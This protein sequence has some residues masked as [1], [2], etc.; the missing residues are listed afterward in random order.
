[1]FRF[2]FAIQMFAILIFSGRSV[3]A[4]VRIFEDT[5]C[6]IYAI[7]D[8]ST[9]PK[10]TLF[11]SVDPHERFVP[12]ARDYA[13]SVNVFIVEFKANG[14]RVMIDTGFG[15]PQGKLM[16]E[17]RKAKIAPKSI[18]DILLT[19]IHPDHVGGLPGFP[20]A[21]VHIAKT[22]YEMWKN[23]PSRKN[24]AKYLPEEENLILFEYAT[25][26]IPGIQAIKCAGHTPGHT[27]FRMKN[28][29]FVGDILHALDLQIAHPSF[30]A[31]YDMN[32]RQAAASRKFAIENFHGEWF[33]AHIP[34]PGKYTPPI[35]PDKR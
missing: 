18:S 28:R 27:V 12:S 14:R 33:G 21:R 4:E 13:G 25:E 30:C 2:L 29:Y 9:R 3:S 19:H 15:A 32:P 10:A 24:L 1:M 5:E 34:F 7:E 35:S 31:R 8:A 6:K 22:E 11:S 17:L 16:N 20:N 23:D 26:V